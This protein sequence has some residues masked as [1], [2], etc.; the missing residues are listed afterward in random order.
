MTISHQ[1]IQPLNVTGAAFLIQI[2]LIGILA[3]TIFVLKSGENRLPRYPETETP[4]VLPLAFLI[5]GFT[6]FSFAILLASEEIAKIFGKL[7]EGHGLPIGNLKARTALSLVFTLDILLFGILIVQT[8]GSKDSPFTPAL[9]MLPSL[10]I[11]LRESP[12]RFVMYALA[13]GVVFLILLFPKFSRRAPD[14][15][16]HYRYSIAFVAI[17]CLALSLFIGYITRPVPIGQLG[18]QEESNESNE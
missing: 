18:E 11:F 3:I 16:P 8:G 6:L 1:A 5:L 7:F 9:I 10:A 2:I 12:E 15:N 4:H 14:D 17:A 13:T